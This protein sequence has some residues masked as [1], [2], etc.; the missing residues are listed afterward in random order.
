MPYPPGMSSH[1]FV[2]AGIDQPHHHEHEWRAD[3]DDSMMFE[4][5]AVIFTEYCGYSEG[6]WGEGYSCE[7]TRILRCDVERVVVVRESK[8][9][10]T[11][12]ASEED[13]LNEWRYIEQLFEDALI[14]VEQAAH[15]GG[16]F[17]LEQIDPANEYGDGYVRVAVDGYKVIY[18]Q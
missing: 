17:V 7:E 12:L 13:H 18:T 9:N 6:R 3:S 14:S 2:R 11:Y 1:D 16:D 4:D 8:P 5:G 10:I 15:S